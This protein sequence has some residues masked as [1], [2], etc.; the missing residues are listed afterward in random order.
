MG[1]RSREC[2]LCGKDYQYC[3]TCSQD[4]MKPA[5]MSEFHSES[6]KNI[7]DIC[8]RF[9][10]DLMSKS[11]AQDAL[12]SCD[13]T[14]KENFKSYVIRDLEVIFAEEPKKR[15]KRSE[16]KIIDEAIV[17]PVAIEPTSHEV[18]TIENE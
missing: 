12:N 9:N 5:W 11:E 14:N 17:E 18:V 4:K 8:T 16:L 13:L 15:G 7:F 6:C 10:M 3:P 1:R 2:Y